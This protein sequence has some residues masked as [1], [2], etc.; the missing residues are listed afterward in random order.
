MRASCAG[1]SS[2][3][4]DACAPAPRGPPHAVRSPPGAPDRCRDVAGS[5]ASA[6]AASCVE[7]APPRP[8]ALPASP[9]C[10]IDVRR[11][12]QAPLAPW[13][14]DRARCRRRLRSRASSASRAAAAR[15]PR[16]ATR[17]GRRRVLDLRHR[18]HFGLEF[19]QLVAQQVEA[20]IAVLGGRFERLEVAPAAAVALVRSA[21]ASVQGRLRSGA[22]RAARAVRR[23][24][25]G[26]G[27]PVDREF[28][29]GTRPVP[30]APAAAPPDRS[31][32]RASGR[33]HRSRAARRS[34]RR[35]RSTAPRAR[36]P[37]R[38]ATR[39]SSAAT[40]ARSAPWRT[41]SPARP[42]AGDQ[43]QRVDDD[44]FSR[45]GLAGQRGQAGAEFELRLHR[46]AP[47]RAIADASARPSYRGLAAVA[48]A[49]PVQLGA[50]Q[51]VVVI[52]RRMQ[53]GDLRIGALD[54]QIVALLEIADGACR[55][56]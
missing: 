45:A 32:R 46:R 56:R 43:Q 7:D 19:A 24:S 10:R 18:R 54:I 48:A 35:N 20:R 21:T 40:S 16:P 42:A 6:S 47:N 12:A 36:R 1:S 15:R 30:A 3:L 55:R 25:P 23:G 41:I 8:E 17:F 22:H 50:Q 51:P 13:P 33:R 52:A 28:R 14:A 38:S 4:R 9:S 11:A 27:I 37:P 29:S 34:R 31:R 44:G 53:Q 2:T 5:G 49:S 26:A 39:R